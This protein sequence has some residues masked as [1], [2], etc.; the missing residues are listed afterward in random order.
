MSLVQTIITL[1]Q[2]IRRQDV[3]DDIDLFNDLLNAR[4]HYLSGILEHE[5]GH[6]DSKTLTQ[7]EEAERD[8]FS[9]YIGFRLVNKSQKLIGVANPENDHDKQRR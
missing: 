4:K 1:W 7:L 5:Q 2:G 3:V 8:A 6:L 9:R